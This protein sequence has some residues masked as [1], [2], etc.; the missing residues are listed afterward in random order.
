[1]RR[2]QGTQRRPA[3]AQPRTLGV[4]AR[5]GRPLEV[6]LD[7]ESDDTRIDV[8]L[9]DELERATIPEQRDHR[10]QHV[11]GSDLM[12]SHGESHTRC[13]VHRFHRRQRER[14]PA[15]CRLPQTSSELLANQLA[16]QRDSEARVCEH[17]GGDSALVPEERQELVFRL[18]RGVPH[19]ARLVLRALERLTRLWCELQQRTPTRCGLLSDNRAIAGHIISL[20]GPATRSGACTRTPPALGSRFRDEGLVLVG[21]MPL[22]QQSRAVFDLDLADGLIEEQPADAEVWLEACDSPWAAYASWAP[23]SAP[24]AVQCAAVANLAVRDASGPAR[25]KAR[26]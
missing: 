15:F 25:E 16:S 12:A 4:F 23:G 6:L 26:K 8:Q 19:R 3:S 11:L 17:V 14:D 2:S 20:S 1:M 7:L 13:R 10:E 24:E 18:D 21:R 22:K 5:T 9:V